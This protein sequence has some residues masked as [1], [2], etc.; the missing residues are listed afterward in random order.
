MGGEEGEEGRGA[1]KRGRKWSSRSRSRR[2]SVRGT[3]CKILIFYG[4][5]N[6]S[7]VSQKIVLYD[8]NPYTGKHKHFPG[9]FRRLI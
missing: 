3:L 5:V 8:L 6:R 2:R 1:K 9:I 4:E 7:T